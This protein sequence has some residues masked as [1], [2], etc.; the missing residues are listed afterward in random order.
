MRPKVPERS[1]EASEV[2]FAFVAYLAA[3]DERLQR[4]CANSGLGG[5]E[6]RE[7]LL[8]PD[9]QG[10]LFDYMLQDETE[11]LAFCGDNGIKPEKLMHLRSQLPGFAE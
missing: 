7:R 11:L 1:R 8:D 2:A 9:F 10:F 4:F 5:D 3:D 6:I